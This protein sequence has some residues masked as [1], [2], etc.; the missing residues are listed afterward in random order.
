MLSALNLLFFAINIF[1]RQTLR[2]SQNAVI[3]VALFL[4]L[5]FYV[6]ENKSLFR[7]CACEIKPLI[8]QY[9]HQLELLIAYTIKVVNLRHFHKKGSSTTLCL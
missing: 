9:N 8:F 3:Y 7:M 2:D 1:H 5:E 6:E 4:F